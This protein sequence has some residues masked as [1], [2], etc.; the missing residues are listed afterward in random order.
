VASTT[1]NS[2]TVR[3]YGGFRFITGE[4]TGAA[5][6]SNAG[7]WSVLCD[8]NTKEHIA[9]VDPG[10]VLDRLGRVPVATWSY[11]GDPE[12]RRYI[13]PMA[14]DFHAAFGLG[15]DDTHI[16]SGDLDGVALAA[17]QGLNQKV[18]VGGQRSEVRIQKLEARLAAQS[19]EMR[20]KDSQIAVLQERL[21]RLERQLLPV[22]QPQAESQ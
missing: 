1:A 17:I 15:D 4:F 2:W 12:E 7:S 21:E 18:E 3:A 9:P 6:P 11:K 20:T 19:E 13:G 14:Q 8:R 16:S 10:D 22:A 5:L